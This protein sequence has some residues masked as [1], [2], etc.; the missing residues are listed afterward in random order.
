MKTKNKK[1]LVGKP[2]ARLMLKAAKIVAIERK[3]DLPSTIHFYDL[4]LCKFA[5][6]V[7]YYLRHGDLFDTSYYGNWPTPEGQFLSRY[8]KPTWEER[9]GLSYC[10]DDRGFWGEDRNTRVIGMLLAIEILKTEGK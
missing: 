8:F 7:Y 5:C 3:E 10:I 1:W 2:D 6:P 9:E 4:N